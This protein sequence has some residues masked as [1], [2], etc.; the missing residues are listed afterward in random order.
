[1]EIAM[2]WL[3]EGI[4]GS[5]RGCLE[6]GKRD[7]AGGGGGLTLRELIFSV[8]TADDFFQFSVRF[9]TPPPPQKQPMLAL[10]AHTLLVVCVY[11]RTKLRGFLQIHPRPL[12]FALESDMME[13]PSEVF[14]R[15]FIMK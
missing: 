1:M 9:F 8:C 14:K 5:F 4:V 12:H 11:M 3:K 2:G 13:N 15:V 6:S 10:K 7:V